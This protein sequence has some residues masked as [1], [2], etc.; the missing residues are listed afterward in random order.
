MAINKILVGSD[1]SEQS[2][3]AVTKAAAL[4]KTTGAELV[5][6]HVTQDAGYPMPS[7]MEA[8]EMA[9]AAGRNTQALEELAAPLRT[10]G[11]NVSVEVRMGYPDEG[12]VAVAKDQAVDL[13]VT[14]TH[15]RTGIARFFLGSIAEKVVR[16]AETNVLVARPSGADDEGFKNILVP[17]D[18]SPAAEKAL[19]LALDLAADGAAVT[20]FHAWHYPAGTMSTTIT[21][22]QDPLAGM[23]AE[24]IKRG[25]SNGAAWV[26]KH[27]RDGISMSFEQSYGP[28]SGAVGDKLDDGDYDL[29]AMGTHGYRGFRRFML[30]SVAEATVRH[31]PCSVV[32]AHG[33]DTES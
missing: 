18:F 9:K 24:I 10:N 28:P 23:K 25:E 6:C 27:Q 17:T 11:V 29:V 8:E 19:R 15:G 32:V 31:A 33:G 12:I 16:L 30:G 2:A 26:E 1:F 3:V 20:L 22:N 13:I 21:S 14:G 7:K 4:A 5:L